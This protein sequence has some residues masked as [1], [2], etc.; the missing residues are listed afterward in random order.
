MLDCLDT[1]RQAEQLGKSYAGSKP[2]VIPPIADSWSVPQIHYKSFLNFIGR[3]CGHWSDATPELARKLERAIQSIADKNLAV[4]ELKALMLAF[5]EDAT[6]KIGK[7]AFQ[8]ACHRSRLLSNMK[9]EDIERLSSVLSTEGAGHVLYVPFMVHIKGVCSKCNDF[10]DR[11]IAPDIA[12]Q[13]LK[14]SL[15]AE[16]T[17][18]PLRSWLVRHT[19]CETFTLTPRDMNGLLREFSVVYRAEDLEAFISELASGDS[20]DSP[21][22]TSTRRIVDTRDL[23]KHL[24]KLRGPWSGFQKELCVKIRNLLKLSD[25]TT[26]G[27]AVMDGQNEY[28]RREY[29]KDTHE[30]AVARKM[31]TRLR[32]LSSISNRLSSA[33]RDDQ[34]LRNKKKDPMPEGYIEA[35]AF[36]Y[37]VRGAGLTLSDKDIGYLADATDFYPFAENVRY[38]AIIEALV[39]D[40]KQNTET[41]R[42]AINHLTKLLWTTATKLH[43]SKNE[44]VADVTCV[45]RGF[46]KNKTGF[47][48]TED[49]QLALS[50]LT[51]PIASNI[52]KDLPLMPAGDGL[53]PYMQILEP[54]LQPPE[55]TERQMRQNYR[56]SSEKD[57]HAF[58]QSDFARTGDMLSTKRRSV[59]NYHRRTAGVLEG[60]EEELLQGYMQSALNDGRHRFKEMSSH[61][62]PQKSPNKDHGYGVISEKATRAADKAK[63][64]EFYEIHKNQF[65]NKDHAVQALLKV[66]RKCLKDILQENGGRDLAYKHM[67]KAFH[68]FDTERT[69]RV[70]PRDFCLAVSVLIGD[71]AIV[72]NKQDWTDIIAHFIDEQEKFVE[73]EV[74]CEKVLNTRELQTVGPSD[75]VG[76]RRDNT[77]TSRRSSSGTSTARGSGKR[78]STNPGYKNAGRPSTSGGTTD[79]YNLNKSYGLSVNSRGISRR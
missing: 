73:Y 45:F 39:A 68:R 59:D 11:D 75:N 63:Q 5:D 76:N 52:V 16:G 56:E 20:E 78:N 31:L 32:A 38:D 23:L 25:G 64:G 29:S 8:V 60:E 54:C 61:G 43:R 55:A 46:D 19:D 50:L 47:I 18:M 9:E 51:I 69:E 37:I 67:L 36:A 57:V 53:V 24:I 30:S 79:D 15:D 6:G 66:V 2:G 28:E 74:F 14:N 3:H 22:I 10:S 58:D 41:N 65:K 72:L 13:L 48:T 49:F 21:P 33:A 26:S 40:T 1:E 7:R 71:D 42:F 34:T 62:S 70:L 27:A 77:A 12:E 4:H 44:W 17:L 35:T